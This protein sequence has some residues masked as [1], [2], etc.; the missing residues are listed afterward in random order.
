M[1][2]GNQEDDVN[3]INDSITLNNSNE[4]LWRD[5]SNVYYAFRQRVSNEVQNNPRAGNTRGAQT[6]L[7]DANQTLD[8]LANLLETHND[9]EPDDWN[10]SQ[11]GFTLQQIANFDED[12]SDPEEREAIR[13]R[14]AYMEREMTH[15]REANNIFRRYRVPLSQQRNTM[16]LILEHYARR[17]NRARG[18]LPQPPAKKPR[19]G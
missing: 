15:N 6:M 4:T 17:D 5:F 13:S 9:R 1:E 8:E 7:N 11:T 12:T 14:N 3:F 10:P 19:K 18:D 16:R 2:G